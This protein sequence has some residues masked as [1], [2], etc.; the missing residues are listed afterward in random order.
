MLLNPYLTFDGSREEAFK[1]YAKA[2]R[3]A[4]SSRAAGAAVI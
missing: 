2:V 1:H 3:P 4:T